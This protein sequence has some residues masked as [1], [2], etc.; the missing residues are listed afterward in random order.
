VP[1]AGLA[2]IEYTKYQLASPGAIKGRPGG[3]IAWVERA[4]QLETRR[5]S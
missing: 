5:P 1:T 3:A 4:Q 2:V